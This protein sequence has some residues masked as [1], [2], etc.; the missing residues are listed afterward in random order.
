[1]CI[2][3]RLHSKTTMH[4]YW[5]KI[6][7]TRLSEICSFAASAGT[8]KRNQLWRLP[9]QLSSSAF[10]SHAPIR[11][12]TFRPHMLH[13]KTI[14]RRC[15]WK[16]Q[17]TRLSEICSLAASAGIA[18][19]NQLWRLLLQLSSSTFY[20]HAPIRSS[21][22][23]PHMLHSKTI[24]RRCWWKIQTTR[25]S[26]IGSLDASAGI[27]KRNQ[28]ERVLPQLFTRMLLFVPQVLDL[29][30]S[31]IHISEPTRPY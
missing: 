7:T 1:M 21:I 12:S 10:Y 4:R 8:A 22:P 29:T 31:L 18:K 25:L 19:R 28:S 27:A 24:M 14:M 9:L 26:E 20:S 6:Q 23:R 3:D 16:I 2:R 17:T 30:L 15:W 5:W 13:N 11:S